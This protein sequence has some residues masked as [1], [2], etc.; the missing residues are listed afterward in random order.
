[1]KLLLQILTIALL[2]VTTS[3]CD[4]LCERQEHAELIIEKVEKFKQNN[5][6]LPKDVT[7]IGLDDTQ[8]HLSFYQIT[9][10]T[11][12]MVW[13]GLSLGESKIYRSETK[14]WTEEG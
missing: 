13:Y 8:M 11:T 4:I 12:Y 2:F 7:E 9:S 1:M 6:R 14:K 5:G 10:D 3:C